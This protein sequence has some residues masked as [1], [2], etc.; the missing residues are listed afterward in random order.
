MNQRDMEL[1]R[2]LYLVRRSEQAIVK[3]YPE[4]EMKTPMHMSMGQEAIPV[5]FCQALGPE[6]QV[7]GSY[8]SHALFLAKTEDPREFF[9]ELYGKETGTAQGKAGSMHL[10]DHRRG[11][12]MSSAIVASTIPLA[13]GSAFAHKQQKSGRIACVFFGDGA[14]DEG[15]FWESLNVASVMKLP[16]MFV[17]EDNNLAVHTEPHIRQGYK[18]VTGVVGSFNCTAF[19]SDS[20]DVEVL[21]QLALDA[22]QSIRTT[23]QPVFL[24]LKCYRYLEHVGISEDFDVGYRPRSEYEEWLRRD[25]VMLQRKR[26]LD[27]G[28]PEADIQREEARIDASIEDGIRQAKADPFPKPE[29]L[30]QGIF[31]E[32]N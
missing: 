13:I 29:A 30:Y 4:N 24:N 3:Y 8:R 31:Y 22:I 15:D 9:A 23:G 26:L 21:H 1:Y 7:F 20:N 2:K 25:C 10:A 6:G 17:C 5:A 27:N 28:C 12:I 32:G 11:H 18:S 19:E 14:L 16:V